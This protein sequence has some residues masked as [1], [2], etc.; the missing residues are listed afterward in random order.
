METLNVDFSQK[1]LAYFPDTAIYCTYYLGDHGPGSHACWQALARKL[2]VFC[3]SK[4]F[5]TVVLL[6]VGFELW[7]AWNKTQNGSR[8]KGM[9]SKDT[10]DK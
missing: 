1:G 6:G 8:P 7:E 5:S 4:D 10:L 3:A 9:G 2:D